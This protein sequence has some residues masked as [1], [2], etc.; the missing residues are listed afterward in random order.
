MLSLC[1]TFLGTGLSVW[2]KLTPMWLRSVNLFL[3][4]STDLL[5]Y[6]I[7][8]ELGEFQIY[9]RKIPL[10]QQ[11]FWWFRFFLIPL[12]CLRYLKNVQNETTKLFSVGNTFSQGFYSNGASIEFFVFI[13]IQGL[14][15][16]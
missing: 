11:N 16:G 1:P 7:K 14:V 8:G 5:T 6:L 12:G 13:A 2:K 4:I 15:I 10:H 9:F 3:V